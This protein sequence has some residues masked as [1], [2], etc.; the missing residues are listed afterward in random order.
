MSSKEKLLK[1]FLST[2]K[3][4]TYEEAVKLLKY[5]GFFQVKTGKTSGSRVRFLNEQY[6]EY[7]IKFHKPHPD[8]Q[9][10]PYI[11]EIIKN[12][13]MDCGLINE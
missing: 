4:F 11:L 6:P 1:R 5:F 8:N 2:P 12:H 13:L 3:D 9:L 7:P 10:K